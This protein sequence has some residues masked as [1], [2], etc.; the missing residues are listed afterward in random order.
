MRDNL[1][2]AWL[3]DVLLRDASQVQ[4][5]VAA[6]LHPQ[7]A[8]RVLHLRAHDESER[9]SVRVDL[10]GEASFWLN[11]LE[12]DATYKCAPR[13]LAHHQHGPERSTTWPSHKARLSTPYAYESASTATH[14]R[15]AE[16]GRRI[17]RTF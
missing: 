12:S 4:S 14:S 11:D 17:S 8:M 6:G 5:L 7:D 9:A 3:Q 10:S 2:L 15:S 13:S 16:T 1:D